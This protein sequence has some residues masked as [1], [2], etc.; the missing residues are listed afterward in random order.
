MAKSRSV[1]VLM[2]SVFLS[3][4][5]Y[6]QETIPPAAEYRQAAA[7]L[8]RLIEHER[9][10]KD[11]P[12]VSIALVA[13][14]KIVWS[15]GF[16]L[17]DPAKN[18]PA[19]A[20][21][22][23]R[24][25][26]VSKLFTDLALMQL[27]EKGE[28]DLDAPVRKY[29]PDFAPKNPS[30]KPITLRQMMSHRSGLT[31]EPAVGHYFDPTGPSLADTVK[32]LN[33]T[34][35]VYPPEARTKYSN[36]AIAVVGQVV[37]TLRKQEFEA[38]VKSTVLDP[39]GLTRTDFRLTPELEAS[40]SK[41]QM[42][43]YDGRK[44]DAPKF[45]L[46]TSSAGNLYSTV[47][48]LGR[49]LAVLMNGGEGPGGRIVKA[50]TL[51]DMRKVQ[52]AGPNASAGFGLGF[53][54][55]NFEGTPRIGH[56]GAV[57]GFATEVAALPEAKLGVAI[58]ASKDCANGTVKRISDDALRLMLAVSRKKP[59][60]KIRMTEAISSQEAR[61]IEG[62][63]GYSAP[64]SGE[65]VEARQSEVRTT[66]RIWLGGAVEVL[67]VLNKDFVIDGPI[68]VDLNAVHPIPRHAQ[69]PED[70]RTGYQNHR[71]LN[72]LP[73]PANSSESQRGLI[74]E[75]GWDHNVL[76]V[77]EREGSLWVLIEWF[78]LYPLQGAGPDH[79]QFS[80][81]GLYD[82]ERADF[83]RDTSGRGTQVKIGD[84]VFKRRAIPGEDGK[85]FQIKPL[86]PVAELRTEALAAK[87]PEDE[88]R[89]LKPDLVDLTTI[90]P[91][92]KLEIRYATDNNFCGTPFY[93]SARAFMQKPAAEAL[94]RAHKA[95]A[96]DGLGLLIHDAYRP[97][98][99]TK[100]FWEAT[101]EAN[102]NFVADPAKGSKH[103]RGCAVDLTMYDLKTGQTVRMVGGYDEFSDRSNPDYP[104]G[105][106][107]QRWYRDR[108]RR[109]MEDQ[110]FTVNEVEWWHFDYQ[111]WSKYPILNAAFE[112]LG[113][114]RAQ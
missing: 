29:L 79:F 87:P 64:R 25:G 37:A 75:Y 84:V 33:A 12:A 58:V 68:Q 53:L 83:T 103:N 18:V 46:G 78:F 101:P 48:D 54:V 71:G 32:S 104:G 86:R 76:Y 57:Y 39:L 45:G 40:L 52:F 7:T 59:L 3:F 70:R 22:V 106:S 8:E 38:T 24:V 11:L 13:D 60:P 98:Y 16:G 111:D 20:E 21:T 97:W 62:I 73:L 27:V 112:D 96:K 36:A 91:A 105:S 5:A 107:R 88:G 113:R 72:E 42:W 82:G 67:R 61:E 110:G 80:N 9:I 15:R 6:G 31:R 44:W 56:G 94:G 65:R 99:V 77:L 89:S 92:I 66:S 55:S 23:Y 4:P 34:E 51:K 114:T 10:A 69:I 19:T 81:V 95:L 43:G 26:S 17:A 30:D 14:G 90:D 63:W 108:L 50:E 47:N 35:L 49:F 109:A 74:G 100:M 28:V 85:T 1:L 93:S 41:G 102:H 2:A